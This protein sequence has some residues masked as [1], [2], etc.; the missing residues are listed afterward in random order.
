M[1][2]ISILLFFVAAQLQ[3]AASSESLGAKFTRLAQA[4]TS[5][6][7]EQKKA[8]ASEIYNTPRLL[9]TIELR[10]E[11]APRASSP[12]D[13]QLHQAALKIKAHLPAIGQT[14]QKESVASK[15]SRHASMIKHSFEGDLDQMEQEIRE[16][17][18]YRAILKKAAAGVDPAWKNSQRYAQEVVSYLKYHPEFGAEF[19]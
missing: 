1:K 10:A 16:N 15:I 5:S 3:G 14:T 2:K 4:L 7:E 8:A 19:K 9:D 11:Q 6:N 17:P 13:K 18:G 12:S